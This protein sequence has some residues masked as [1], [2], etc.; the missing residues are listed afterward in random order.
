[1]PLLPFDDDTDTDDEPPV[2]LTGIEVSGT[3]R[4]HIVEALRLNRKILH[5]PQPDADVDEAA[6]RATIDDLLDRLSEAS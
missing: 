2:T 3:D 1:M 5:E 6:V 4:E